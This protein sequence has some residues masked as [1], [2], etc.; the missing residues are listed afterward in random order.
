MPRRALLGAGLAGLAA[1]YD[2]VPP[3][4]LQPTQSLG[5]PAGNPCVA[6]FGNSSWQLLSTPLATNSWCVARRGGTLLRSRPC[7]GTERPLF[8][9][10]FWGGA[11]TRP[12]PARTATLTAHPPKHPSPQVARAG[13]PQQPGLP[14]LHVLFQLVR[15][16]A[17]L[18]P[19]TLTPPSPCAAHHPPTCRPS[20]PPPVNPPPPPPPL[21]AHPRSCLNVLPTDLPRPPWTYPV[22]WW[23]TWNCSTTAG[24]S[25]NPTA[26]QSGPA[27]A[28][29]LS[30]LPVP[31]ADFCHRLGTTL[32]KGPNTNAIN[33]KLI[34]TANP[35]KG[36]GVQYLG[37]DTC[38]N[39]PSA[40]SRSLT[41]WLQCDEDASGMINPNEVVLE[42]GACS[43]E[44]FIKSSYG[45][46]FQCP[47]GPDPNT[48]AN[49]LCSNHGFCDFDT[50]A[51]NSKCFCNDG[52][53]GADCGSRA[54]AAASGLS[55]TGGVL[56]AVCLFLVGT[57]AFL[58]FLWYRIRS[59]RLDP[60]AYSALRAGPDGGD[61]IKGSLQGGGGA[62]FSST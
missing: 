3:T 61:D 12:Y 57:L 62:V 27:P 51:Q 39:T 37:G 30:N 29:Q 42:T 58:G 48:G 6:D 21:G 46:P 41:V 34:D 40:P 54:A 7:C 33:Y 19:T 20:P 9:L 35:S 22:N 5:I 50:S 56:V 38:G 23:P 53:G 59:L 24:G 1:A 14:Q 52:W 4:F 2:A 47:T 49:K 28:F 8:S 32:V 43:Y 17:A 10:I 18:P 31:Q 55:A 16:A 25:G 11:P 13:Q 60:A 36:V 26:L 15:A 44:I 45:C